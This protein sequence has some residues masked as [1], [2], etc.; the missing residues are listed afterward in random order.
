MFTQRFTVCDI[1]VIM[2][3]RLHRVIIDALA[4]YGQRLIVQFLR[5]QLGHAL[6][7][8]GNVKSS[9]S[10]PFN[11]ENARNRSFH[12]HSIFK[13]PQMAHFTRIHFSLGLKSLISYISNFRWASNHPFQ[14]FSFFIG[15]QIAHFSRFRF[16][17]TRKDSQNSSIHFHFAPGIHKT[18]FF[19]RLFASDWQ[20]FCTF[21]SCFIIKDNGR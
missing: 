16:Q 11:Y 5:P 12:P 7:H 3:N 6:H 2:E 8:E 14:P 4:V 19:L 1:K 21:A 13:T 10:A 15:P 20:K 9:V 17:F 18:L